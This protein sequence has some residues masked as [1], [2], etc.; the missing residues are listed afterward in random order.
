MRT[1]TIILVALLV[2]SVIANA[3]L[4]Y[5]NFSL[6]IKNNQQ[7]LT[8][9]KQAQSIAD[10]QTRL[11]TTI[12]QYNDVVASLNSATAAN[13]ELLVRVDQLEDEAIRTTRMMNDYRIRMN[14]AESY[15]SQTQCPVMLD[16]RKIDSARRN[17][18]VRGLIVSV[19]DQIYSG[20]SLSSQWITMWDNSKSAVLQVFSRG[21]I[22]TRFIVSWRFDNSSIQTIYDVG[23]GCV[24]YSRDRRGS[25]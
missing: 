15:V 1:T 17:E 2:L 8:I 14:V 6:F 11:A 5:T 25:W 4:G 18:D 9:T 19:H 7:Q 21:N 13:D 10:T 3:V 12:T 24:M 16:E 22:S 20:R 23:L